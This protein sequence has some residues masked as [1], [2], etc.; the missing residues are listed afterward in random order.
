MGYA[1][2]LY[3]DYA[4]V[5]DVID[6]VQHIPSLGKSRAIVSL[7]VASALSCSPTEG[8]TEEET[9]IARRAVSPCVC[10]TYVHC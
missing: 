5:E 6:T 10:A 1:D 2:K 4:S 8:S 3:G 7:G 9:P